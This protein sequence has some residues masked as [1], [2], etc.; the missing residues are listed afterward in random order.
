M[1]LSGDVGNNDVFSSML[2]VIIAKNEPKH[3][4]GQRS[5]SSVDVRVKKWRLFDS[6]LKLLQIFCNSRLLIIRRFFAVDF[7]L[8]ALPFPS[9]VRTFCL[10][11]SS[12][13]T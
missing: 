3:F 9:S 1:Q 10:F 5:S 4:S 13:Q 11:P 6:L 8:G 7:T 12:K 2:V